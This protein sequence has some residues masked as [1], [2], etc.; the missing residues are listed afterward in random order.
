ML[1]GASTCKEANVGMITVHFSNCNEIRMGSPYQIG[2]LRLEGDWTPDLKERGW[3]SLLSRSQDERYLCLV[4]WD[5]VGNTPGF[6]VV[7]VDEKQKSVEVSQR[8][9]GCCESL[10]WGED[11]IIWKAFPQ[12]QGT[13]VVPFNR[14]TI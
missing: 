13:L 9:L 5:T 3:Q 8:I 12:S 14:P 6:R 2:S 1:L 11:V 10:A 4:E 7:L